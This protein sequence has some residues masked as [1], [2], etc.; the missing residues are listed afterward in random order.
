KKILEETPLSLCQTISSLNEQPIIKAS[1]T[2]TVQLEWWLLSQ[3]EAVEVLQPS[4]LREN[5]RKR[6]L[7]AAKH[8]K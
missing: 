1:V 8:Y 6:L 2:Y 4:W 3:A 5:I 7:L